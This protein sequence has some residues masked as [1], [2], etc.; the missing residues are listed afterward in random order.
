[1]ADQT[2]DLKLKEFKRALLS[3]EEALKLRKSKLSRD[4]SI[5]RFEFSYELGWKVSKEFLRNRFGLEIA[6]PKECFRELKRQEILTASETETAME[7]VTDRNLIVHTYNEK[8][9][10]EIFDLIKK[11][12]F[13]LL[14]NMFHKIYAKK[15]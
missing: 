2:L 8:F 13:I 12:Y 1:M 6:S 14:G 15:D 9:A 3:L 4:S 11:K 7:M 5:K 10:D